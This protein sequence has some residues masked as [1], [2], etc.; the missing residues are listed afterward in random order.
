MEGYFEIDIENSI[1]YLIE[2]KLLKEGIEFE[3]RERI[4][5]V[6]ADPCIT[7][8][9]ANQNKEIVENIIRDT[10]AEEKSINKTS[11]TNLSFYFH[12]LLN[13]ILAIALFFLNFH[14]IQ[15]AIFEY[16]GKEIWITVVIVFALSLFT[17]YA[18]FGNLFKKKH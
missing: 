12:L 11:E 14:F 16:K 2:Q 15:F 7:L 18:M 10:L 6:F 13:I 4:T 8:T 3:K 9:I 17:L 1:A 5:G